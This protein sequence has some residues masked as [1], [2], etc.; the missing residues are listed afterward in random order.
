MKLLLKCRYISLRIPKNRSEDIDIVPLQSTRLAHI[1]PSHWH[2]GMTR[3]W[4]ECVLNH[5]TLTLRSKWIRVKVKTRYNMYFIARPVSSKRMVSMIL[6]QS[7][8]VDFN[9]FRCDTLTI[10]EENHVQYLFSFSIVCGIRCTNTKQITQG[11]WTEEKAF[12][13]FHYKSSSQ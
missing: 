2:C 3:A 5:L 6:S 11:V 9:I 1:G 12:R 13:W 4:G 8:F 7:D 10:N